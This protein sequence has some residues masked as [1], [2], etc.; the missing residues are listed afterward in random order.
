[1]TAGSSAPDATSAMP[2]R[3]LCPDTRPACPAS[4]PARAANAF[5]RRATKRRPRRPPGRHWSDGSGPWRCRRRHAR[6]PRAAARQ[7]V[8]AD[9]EKSAVAGGEG[10]GHRALRA[11]RQAGADPRSLP[12]AG[13]GRKRSSWRPRGEKSSGT[14]DAGAGA[15]RYV[16]GQ[17]PDTK[18]PATQ[19]QENPAGPTRFPPRSPRLAPGPPPTAVA[20]RPGRHPAGPPT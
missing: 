20:G 7:Q 11:A 1:M 8:A 4:R 12:E 15:V 17:R 6:G 19:P 3:A 2:T 16:R 18:P 13:P 9:E 10:G 14:R 5:N